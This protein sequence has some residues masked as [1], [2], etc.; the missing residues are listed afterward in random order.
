MTTITP[1]TD[2]AVEAADNL[3]EELTQRLADG[4]LGEL[5]CNFL[6]N[7]PRIC[8]VLVGQA[9]DRGFS[10]K[11]IAQALARALASAVASQLITMN[12]SLSVDIKD[13][14][15]VYDEEYR[16][17]LRQLLTDKVDEGYARLEVD[18]AVQ[19]P[20]GSRA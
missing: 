8:A 3:D 12:E 11:L 19:K 10:P 7:V 6:L 17:A 4:N 2:A 5:D 20:R 14:Q 18:A 16:T 9:L 15:S 1:F 13:M